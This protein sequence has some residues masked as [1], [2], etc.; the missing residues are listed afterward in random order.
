MGQLSSLDAGAQYCVEDQLAQNMVERLLLPRLEQ[1]RESR[2]R[3]YSSVLDF[4][5]SSSFLIEFV[6]VS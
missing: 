4:S 6:I 1:P 2:E 3:Q 5:F